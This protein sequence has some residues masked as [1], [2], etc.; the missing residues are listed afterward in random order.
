MAQLPLFAGGKSFG[1]RMTS[2]AQASAP[3]ANVVGLVFFGFPWHTP[4]QPATVRGEHLDAIGIPMLFLQGERD[5]MGDP[6]LVE[7]QVEG[8]LTRAVLHS[9]PDA[10]HSFHVPVKSGRTDPQVQ[11][12]LARTMAQW[13]A[14][15]T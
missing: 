6:K 8:H 5:A 14:T 10:D 1:G 11:E 15:L 13:I 12:E 4:K 7:K 3:L 9:V 2:Q